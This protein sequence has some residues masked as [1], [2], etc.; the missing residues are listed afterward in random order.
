MHSPSL[1]RFPAPIPRSDSPLLPMP[2]QEDSPQNADKSFEELSE[3]QSPGI[4]REF[5]DFLKYNKKWW[6][7]P[8]IAVLLLVAALILLTTSGAAP[9]LY[10]FW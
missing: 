8:I 9:F 10:T 4:V 2:N 5:I 6:L 7:T 1:L 3:E